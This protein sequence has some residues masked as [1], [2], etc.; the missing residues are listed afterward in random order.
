MTDRKK[1]SAGFWMTVVLVA[2]LVYSGSIG[3]A[4]WIEARYATED[5]HDVLENAYRP[6]LWTAHRGPDFLQNALRWY[7]SI[8]LAAGDDADFDEESIMIGTIL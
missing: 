6:V 4:T 1:P 5:S 7:L 2:M 3:P 8:G